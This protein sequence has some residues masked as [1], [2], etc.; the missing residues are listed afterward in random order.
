MRPGDNEEDLF[1]A[2][3]LIIQT[4][5]DRFFA[6]NCKIYLAVFKKPFLYGVCLFQKIYLY[7]RM[8]SWAAFVIF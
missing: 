6:E 5:M 2:Q 3:F 7:V 8:R 4:G 1:A